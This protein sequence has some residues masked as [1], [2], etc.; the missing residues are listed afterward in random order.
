MTTK[1]EKSKD[2]LPHSETVTIMRSHIKFAP[3]NPKRHSDSSIKDQLKNFKRAGYLGGIV[4]NSVTG[5]LVSGHKRIMALDIYHNYDGQNN[6]YEVKVEKVSYDQKMEMEQNIFMDSRS[7]NSPQQYDML[8]EIFP[9]IDLEFAGLDD[10]EVSLILAENP[11]LQNI[12]I[13]KTDDVKEDFNKIEKSAEQKKQEIKNLKSQIMNSIDTA[14]GESY[15]T[16]SFDSYENKAQF[17]EAM[18]YE[19]SEL[20]IIKGE[21]LFDKINDIRAMTE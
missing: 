8:A 7:T 14:Q 15:I 16:L 13:G 2:S 17:L 10:I 9:K 21:T 19:D 1:K 5:N 11:Q 18:G 6:D 12:S 20:I 4:W 3:Y